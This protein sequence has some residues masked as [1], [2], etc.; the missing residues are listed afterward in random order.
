M[1]PHGRRLYQGTLLE[2]QALRENHQAAFRHGK[3]LLGTS[4]GL[5]SLDSKIPA[6]VVIPSL[7]RT[8]ASTGE[9][10]A[11]RGP[12]PGFRLSHTISDRSNNS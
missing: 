1:G 10:W 12:H 9:L 8:A 3:I 4:G 5:E 11:G 2:R 7:A 6:D